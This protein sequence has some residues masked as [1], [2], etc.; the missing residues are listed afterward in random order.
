[1]LCYKQYQKVSFLKCLI[2]DNVVKEIRSTHTVFPLDATTAFTMPTWLVSRCAYMASNHMRWLCLFFP[3]RYFEIPCQVVYESL[4]SQIKMWGT[5][6]GCTMGG[7]RCL[8]KVCMC[9]PCTSVSD[10]IPVDCSTADYTCFNSRCEL[11][12]CPS[13]MDFHAT[14]LLVLSPYINNFPVWDH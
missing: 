4:V 13:C 1:M 3:C 12:W 14:F 2:I 5:M 9:A 8:Y 10:F 7:Q 11:L 6:A